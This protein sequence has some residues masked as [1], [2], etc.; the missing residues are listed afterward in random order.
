MNSTPRGLLKRVFVLFTPIAAIV[1]VFGAAPLYADLY[2]W[3]DA[4][5]VLHITDDMGK[6]PE[7]KRHGVKVFKIKPQHKRRLEN[8]PIYIPPTR[9]IKKAPKLYGEHTL[10]WWKAAFDNLHNEIDALKDG[11]DKKR[12]FIVVFEGG[13]R[14]GQM[15]GESEVAN[16]KRY[17]KEIIKDRE[18]LQEKEDKLETLQKNARIDDVPREII[19]E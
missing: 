2:K 19:D 13:R 9:V 1:F 17:K 12:Q 14:F 15:F 8:V 10:D 5:G 18:A 7:H 11:I 16:Y 4:K 3:E 6:V